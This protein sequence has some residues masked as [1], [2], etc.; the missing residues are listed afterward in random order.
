MKKSV[1]ILVLFVF[2]NLRVNAQTGVFYQMNNDCYNRPSEVVSTIDGGFLF[3]NNSAPQ[4]TL[5]YNSTFIK[6]S[7]E[8]FV[9]NSYCLSHYHTAYCPIVIEGCDGYYHIIGLAKQSLNDTVYLVAYSVSQQLELLDSLQIP[10]TTGN[11]EHV[12]CD[13]K[14]DSTFIVAAMTL[15]PNSLS[16]T[17]LYIVEIDWDFLNY[18]VVNIANDYY[19]YIFSMCYSS[20][21]S[22]YFATAWGF[23]QNVTDPHSKLLVLDTSFRVTSVFNF[24]GGVR[25]GRSIHLLNDTTLRYAANL[26]TTSMNSQDIVSVNESLTHN[27]LS[28]IVIGSSDTTDAVSTFQTIIPCENGSEWVFYMKNYNSQ[29]LFPCQ[30]S[31]LSWCRIN[32]EMV[33]EIQYFY[34]GDS[35]YHL[36]HASELNNKDMMLS[37]SKF[38]VFSGSNTTDALL[39][40]I[41]SDG[42]LTSTP[43][44]P[45]LQPHHA[46]VY[47]NPGHG[48]LKVEAGPQI[49]GATF[50]LFDVSGQRVVQQPIQTSVTAINTAALASGVYPWRII[51]KGEVVEEGKWVK[52]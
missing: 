25:N 8:G 13:V 4:G 28:R 20:V 31:W 44:N 38:D 3:A 32:S 15:D 7:S 39:L 33:C 18:R 19:T 14:N 36:L 5:Y 41:N 22:S 29:T 47:P 17:S 1:I 21:T 9:T 46:I 23:S 52:E 6:L 35:Y 26:E 24:S 11:I 27:E 45:A 12:I 37:V 40:K 10:L 30:P 49:F 34:G 43:E 42:L 2:T 48:V 50:E 16:I 51:W